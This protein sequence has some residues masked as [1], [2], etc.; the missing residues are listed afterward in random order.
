MTSRAGDGQ[1]DIQP[2]QCSSTA[3]TAIAHKAQISPFA[4]LPLSPFPLP[5]TKKHK[6][7][8]ARPAVRAHVVV[9]GMVVAQQGFDVA[10]FFSWKAC[11]FAGCVCRLNVGLQNPRCS[12]T[13]VWNATFLPLC[14]VSCDLFISNSLVAGGE[15]VAQL[16]ACFFPLLNTVNDSSRIAKYKL[17]KK[18]RNKKKRRKCK[19]K[20][21][22]RNRKKRSKQTKH[23]KKICKMHN[24]VPFNRVPGHTSASCTLVHSSNPPPPPTLA[25]TT[26]LPPR[27][28]P[29]LFAPGFPQPN[30]AG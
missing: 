10:F 15:D 28:S 22:N 12:A 23:D 5:A 7:T 29:P 21:T 24:L 6:N 18:T 11:V 26:P 19:Q 14:L 16:F 9:S 30:E 3:T 1:P 8:P 4:N 2:L 27:Q 25:R 17:K 20:Q 13:V